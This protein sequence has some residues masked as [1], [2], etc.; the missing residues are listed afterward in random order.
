MYRV[1]I[2]DSDLDFGV[3]IG[4]EL[5][6]GWEYAVCTEGRHL[7]RLLLEEKW[8][9]LVLDW[10]LRGCDGEKSLQMVRLL[11]PG[12]RVLVTSAFFS[13]F[14]LELLGK[15]GVSYFIRK[16]CG[17][18]D[19][20]RRAADLLEQKD[21]EVC[22][23]V[24]AAN[25]LR[26]LSVPK[27]LRG[28]RYLRAAVTVL[29]QNPQQRPGPA[30]YNHLGAAWGSNHSQVERAMSGAIR[31]AWETRQEPLWQMYFPPEQGKPET[32]PDVER[33]L[34]ALCSYQD[35]RKGGERRYENKTGDSVRGDR[36]GDDNPD[37]FRMFCREGGGC[38][39]RDR[40]SACGHGGER[41]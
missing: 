40:D 12:C 32:R 19:V 5:P 39:G 23:E 14:L 29:L 37:F 31:E 38:P 21:W 10:M 13:E 27:G 41:R 34:T 1:L 2:G 7:S 17:A 11:H 4:K 22:P 25:M 15:S 6:A 30:L 3:Q 9:V 20:S 16:P 18:Q 26:T 33:F 36:S 24:V 35:R 28:Y 8:D